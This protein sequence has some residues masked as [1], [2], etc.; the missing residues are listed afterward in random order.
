MESP[1]G[2]GN[3]RRSFEKVTTALAESARPALIRPLARR[4]AAPMAMDLAGFWLLWQLEG[5]F[6]GLR[7]LGMSRS[8]IYRRIRD[9]RAT[10]GVHPD[11]FEM[12]GVKVDL[13]AYL[14]GA[15]AAA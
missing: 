14:T 2:R 6:E 9:F 15:D 13:A 10:M 4:M 1:E 8:S 12:P 3:A 5:G 7:S 11:E